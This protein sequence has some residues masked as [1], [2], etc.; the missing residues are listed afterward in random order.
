MKTNNPFLYSDDNKR[1]HTWNYY[2][3]HQFGKKVAKVPL[4]GGFTCPNRDGTCGTGGCTFCTRSGSGE[5]AGDR[6]EP[7]L[8]QYAKG[9]A[10][11]RHKWP[12]AD[13]I[14]YFQAYTNTYG[15]L[16][17]IQDCLTPFLDRPEVA[18]IAIATRADCL[19][20]EKIDWLAQCCV[21]KEIWLELGVQSV[22]DRTARQIHRGHDYAQVV[23]TVTRLARTP[24]KICVHLINGLPGEDAAMMLETACQINQLPIHAVKLHML[25]LMQDTQLADAYMQQPFP[26]L[27]RDE[28]VA[29]VVDQLE[30]LRPEIIIQRLT[31]DGAGEALIAP[32]WT[33]KKTIVLNEIDKRM[34]N[35]NTWQGKLV[36][37][38]R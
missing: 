19:E 26:L 34:A 38:G 10:M 30:R 17:K 18:A 22:H 9:Q 27:T 23:E 29:I 6:A 28:Y 11:M 2:L 14:P 36:S 8:S 5:F 16:S 37:N 35:L 33:K 1:Y 20:Q 13:F 15:P 31:G 24:L 7:L 25:H 4:D 12:D 32:E 21:K 3:R